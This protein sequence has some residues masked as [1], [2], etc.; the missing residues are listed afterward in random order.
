MSLRCPKC[1]RMTVDIN[2]RLG[3]FSCFRKDCDWILPD[4][5]MSICPICHCDH[6]SEDGYLALGT[7]N[8][9][10]GSFCTK[11]GTRFYYPIWDWERGEK[12]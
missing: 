2:P 6:L 4:G 11:C 5:Y 12:S 1:H 10:E 8:W 3:R 7:C 9:H